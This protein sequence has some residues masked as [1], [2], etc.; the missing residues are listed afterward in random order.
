[1][2][3]IVIVKNT[4]ESDILIH[5]KVVDAGGQRDISE[6]PE[7]VLRE[8]AALITAIN[9]GDIVINDGANDLS[10]KD[11]LLYISSGYFLRI[12][13]NGVPVTGDITL[14]DT[15]NFLGGIII[16]D[17]LTGEVTIES[18]G[19]GSGGTS[20]GSYDDV[21]EYGD[22][23]T[24]KN[25]FMKCAYSAHTSL[26]STSIAL[27]DGEVVHATISTEKDATNNW[28]V[29]VIINGVKG[30]SG[31]YAGGT[32]IGSDIEKTTAVLDKVYTDLTGYDFSAGDR[33]QVYV[34][35]GT[36]GSKDAVEPVVRL[37][38]RYD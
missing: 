21:L 20:F 37:Y 10:V 29:Q 11:G 35:E 22:S 19:G 32:Q 34:K 30:G 24:I 2:A 18:S 9:S 36:L 25:K 4:T 14:V 16:V 5:G 28:F 17:Q 26:D 7:I 33:I 1:M 8:D 27:G 15:L 31:Q 6:V 13:I 23:G 38:V 3:K 12:L